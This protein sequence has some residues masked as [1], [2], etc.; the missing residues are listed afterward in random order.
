MG[1][2]G[3]LPRIP[4][5]GVAHTRP[6]RRRASGGLT[7][8]NKEHYSRWLIR[9]DRPSLDL[10]CDVLLAVA[11]PAAEAYCVRP[12]CRLPALTKLAQLALLTTTSCI[13]QKCTNTTSCG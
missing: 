10:V 11:K 7:E 8:P 4:K 9:D 2:S 6:N 1:A 3:P 5:V 13:Q 12:Q